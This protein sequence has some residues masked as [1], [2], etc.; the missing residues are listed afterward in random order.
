MFASVFSI[1][2]D[3][4]FFFCPQLE[5]MPNTTDNQEPMSMRLHVHYI[6]ESTFARIFLFLEPTFQQETD[7]YINL[8]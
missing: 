4:L 3:N 5:T 1:S 2:T 6:L 7:I 8:H